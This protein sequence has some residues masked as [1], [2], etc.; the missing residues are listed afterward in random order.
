MT[1]DS[2]ANQVR[3]HKSDVAF[4]V[5][6]RDIFDQI[7]NEYSEMT[8]RSETGNI[9]FFEHPLNN[10]SVICDKTNVACRDDIAGIFLNA[11][12]NP[13]RIVLRSEATGKMV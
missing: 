1:K 4:L 12:K 7:A 2:M 10:V 6:P 5:V 13:T 3:E 9:T 8:L 11:A